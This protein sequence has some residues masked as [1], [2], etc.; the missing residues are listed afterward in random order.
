MWERKLGRPTAHRISMLKGLV[1]ELILKEK[2]TTTYEK[3]KE[4]QKLADKMVT[5]GKKGTLA[6]RRQANRYIT[7]EDALTKVFDT[8]A[9]RFAE[10]PGGYTRVIKLGKRRG[11]AAEMAVIEFV[12]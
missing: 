10:R 6:S 4:V 8:L 2:I 9:P 7:I 1:S 5:F 12:E 3:A 11:D